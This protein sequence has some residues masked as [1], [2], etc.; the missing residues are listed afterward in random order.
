M[1]SFRVVN[2]SVGLSNSRYG[3]FTYLV[4]CRVLT[5]P[6]SAESN[7]IIIV[8]SIWTTGCH[9]SLKWR[10]NIWFSFVFWFIVLVKKKKKN[11]KT[12]TFNWTDHGSVYFLKVP[13]DC[14][15]V[16]T[17]C[18][19]DT[20]RSCVLYSRHP[21]PLGQSVRRL[22]YLDIDDGKC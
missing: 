8:P 4:L 2:S 3:I 13:K 17:A 11:T 12:M 20:R 6:A 18:C 9:S 19:W 1:S 22:F 21:R 7:Y 5:S 15:E 14:S 16:T 10:V